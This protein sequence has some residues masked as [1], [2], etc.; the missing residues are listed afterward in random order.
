MSSLL[1]YRRLL[2]KCM[3]V[4]FYASIAFVTIL[5]LRPNLILHFIVCHCVQSG[6]K[7]VAGN[8]KSEADH[9]TSRRYATL[10]PAH[11]KDVYYAMHLLLSA[12]IRFLIHV[13]T[14]RL[15]TVCVVAFALPQ[16]RRSAGAQ[17]DHSCSAG[18][19][20]AFTLLYSC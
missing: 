12:V 8:R 15:F 11:R 10:T 1:R 16:D 7:P 6:A 3:L 9:T 19:S 5:I 13:M 2:I 18:T 14:P 17:R 20:H 4:N